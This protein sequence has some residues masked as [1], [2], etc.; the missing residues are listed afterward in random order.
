MNIILFQL[1]LLLL[2]A[3]SLAEY[4]P[5]D[6]KELGFVKANLICSTCNILA[7]YNLPEAAANC[8]ECCLKDDDSQRKI[9]SKAVLEICKCK[10]GAY[11]QIEAF[12]NSDLPSNFKNLQIRFVNGLDP[13]IRL[14][15]NNVKVDDVDI[16]KWNT[17]SVNE[18]LSTYLSKD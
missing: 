15:E 1:P 17:D 11:P 3:S 7:E 8:K 12:I 18:F 9:Y 14:Y 16:H 4:S 13:I 2:I 5:E 10:Y 6:C